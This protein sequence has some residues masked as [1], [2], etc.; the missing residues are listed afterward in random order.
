M[1]TKSGAS[2]SLQVFKQGGT[3]VVKSSNGLSKIK[4][5]SGMSPQ[6]YIRGSVEHLLERRELLD[7]CQGSSSSGTSSG[8][9]Y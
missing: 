2:H 4:R 8:P 6:N 7:G 5:G 3:L 1:L 9:E